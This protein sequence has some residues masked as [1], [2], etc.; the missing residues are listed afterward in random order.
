MNQLKMDEDRFVFL[1]IFSAIFNSQYNETTLAYNH[2]QPL[3][4]HA[5][6]VCLKLEA[7]PREKNMCGEFSEGG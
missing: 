3:K 7:T 4:L 2:N 6:C 5:L 1:L